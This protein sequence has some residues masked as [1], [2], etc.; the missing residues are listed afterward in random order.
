MCLYFHEPHFTEGW[1]LSC[2]CAG[3]F[4]KMPSISLLSSSVLEFC[5]TSSQQL[6][7]QAL[8]SFVLRCA[9][10]VTPYC[11][12]ILDLSLKYLSYD[13]NFTDDMDED[14]DEDMNG[15]EDEDE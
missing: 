8:E 7:L 4:I 14:Q 5:H 13:P 1:V 15:D 11:E 3:L 6:I 9:R 2:G 10:E 12:M